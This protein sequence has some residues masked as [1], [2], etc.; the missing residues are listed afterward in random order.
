LVLMTMAREQCRFLGE[1][2]GQKLA[3]TTAAA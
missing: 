1:R 2:Y 3:K